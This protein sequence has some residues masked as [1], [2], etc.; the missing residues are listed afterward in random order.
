[1]DISSTIP[2][3]TDFLTQDTVL[4]HISVQKLLKSIPK[5]ISLSTAQSSTDESDRHHIL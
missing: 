2:S 5:T 4:F 3:I 1:M